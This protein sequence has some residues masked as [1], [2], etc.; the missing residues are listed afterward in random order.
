[1][2]A[3]NLTPDELVKKYASLIYR[4]AYARLQNVPDAEDITQE[5]LLK[6]IKADK[7]FND[8]DHRRM[9]L[10]RVT[11]NA[12]NSLARTAWHKTTVPLD[13]AEELSYTDA[14]PLGI[15]DAVE[16]LPEKYRIPIHLYYF[17][18]M[19]IQQISTAMDCAEGTI[20]S[21]LSRGRSLLKQMLKEEDYV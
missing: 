10:I 8:E 18:D 14:E 13:E 15:R 9:W 2:G 17:Q 5:V 4:V 20:K 6:Y 21:L 1:M 16:R 7:R 11:V 12:V 3:E 19:T